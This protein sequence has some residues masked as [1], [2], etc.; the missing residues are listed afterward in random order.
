MSGCAAVR[1]CVCVSFPD[2]ISETISQI[3]FI[4]HTHISGGVDVP[5]GGYDLCSS[6]LPL[7]FEAIIDFN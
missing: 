6:F 7:I 4:L 3:A 2:D 5:F 1:A